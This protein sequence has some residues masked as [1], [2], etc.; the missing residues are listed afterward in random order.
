M[1]RARRQPCETG[2]SLIELLVA[3]SLMLIVM[4]SVFHTLNPVHGSFQPNRRPLTSSSVCEW[5]PMRCRATCAALDAAWTRASPQGPLPTFSRRFSRCV[6]A[7]ETP[8]QPAV[9]N[10]RDHAAHGRRRRC[11]NHDRPTARR[12]VFD[13]DGERRSW[14]PSSI[15]TAASEPA[16]RSLPSTTPGRTTR[17]LSRASMRWASIFSTTCTIPRKPTRRTLRGSQRPRAARIT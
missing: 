11:T 4:S 8:T 13:G 17:S 6:R 7:D 3:V 1:I 14:L 16:C 10:R 2:F 12:H 15:R 5:P 9:Q